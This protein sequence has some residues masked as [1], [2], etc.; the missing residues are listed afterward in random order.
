MIPVDLGGHEI[1]I[2]FQKGQ[3]NSRVDS[4][5]IKHLTMCEKHKDHRVLTLEVSKGNKQ[6]ISV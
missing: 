5:L 6:V 4:E 3:Q 2:F 1:I